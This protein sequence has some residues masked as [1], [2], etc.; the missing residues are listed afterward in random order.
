[1]MILITLHKCEIPRSAQRGIL[2]RKKGLAI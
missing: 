2:A 1:M